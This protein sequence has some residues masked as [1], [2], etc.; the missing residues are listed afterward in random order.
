[1]NDPITSQLITLVTQALS[2]LNRGVDGYQCA[3]SLIDLNGDLAYDTLVQQINSAGVPV[4]I[5]LAKGIPEISMQVTAYEQPLRTF[6]EE[7]LRGPQYD[8]TED[9]KA[10]PAAV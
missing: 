5:E 2:C 9:D 3:Q 1:V 10:R 8:E 7:F 6:I 4:M